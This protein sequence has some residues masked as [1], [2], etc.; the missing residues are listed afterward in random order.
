MAI[1]T[2]D[3]DT[4]IASKQAAGESL[5]IDKIVFAYFDGLDTSATPPKAEGKPSIS[6]IVATEN[7][8]HIGRVNGNTVVY[9]IVM[10][11]DMG[12]WTFNWMGLYSSAE[13]KVIAIAYTPIQQKR[14]TVGD[15]LGNVYNKNFALEF[16]GAADTTGA[17]IDAASWQID[18]TARLQTMDEIQRASIKNVYGQA[19]FIGDAMRV[20]FNGSDYIIKSGRA[21][22]GGLFDELVSDRVI[23]PGA[24]PKTIWLDAYQQKTM[25]GVQS[26]FDVVFNDGSDLP[27]Y[28]AD[29]VGHS[30]IKLATINSQ[31]NI[32]DHRQN[33]MEDFEVF[34]K[35]NSLNPK[36]YGLGLSDDVPRPPDQNV[37]NLRHAGFYSVDD[38]S[39]GTPTG[40]GGT[41]ICF[42]RNELN[43]TL[44]FIEAN[45]QRLY[46][47]NRQSD[48]WQDKWQAIGSENS[49]SAN[50]KAG[51]MALVHT[52]AALLM[53]GDPGDSSDA[54]VEGPLSRITCND[55]GGNM[56]IRR[57]CYF[58]EG[59]DRYSA[60]G[61]GAAKIVLSTDSTDG[62]VQFYTA[63]K[64]VKGEVITWG[65]SFKIELN[66]LLFNGQK[67][68]DRSDLSD[69]V[70]STSTA[71]PASSKAVK[72]AYDLAGSKA[73]SQ[74]THGSEDLP[75][76]TITGKGVV[77]L[78]EIL[79]G[80]SK[81]KALAEVVGKQLQD[82][83][84]SLSSS[85]ADTVSSLQGEIDGKSSTGHG[86]SISDVSGL[87]DELDGK[88]DSGH[89]HAISGISGL[90]EAL[91]AKSNLTLGSRVWQGTSTEIDFTFGQGLY[92]VF[93]SP[94]VGSFYM[95]GLFY[96]GS[97]TFNAPI[98]I[99]SNFSTQVEV[100]YGRIKIVKYNFGG[101]SERLNLGSIYRVG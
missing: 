87:Q 43:T 42:S 36:H 44:L 78:S 28:V 82:S 86:H 58:K 97:N 69:S 57:G 37:L 8:T 68:L 46:F 67:V 20:Q 24:L 16:L 56:C 31:S 65:P 70:S 9:S 88:T 54:S 94:G 73:N 47:R 101:S 84:N 66:Q 27:D 92:Y 33:V 4:L 48:I 64:G 11:S 72:S 95:P 15:V 30:F 61:Y 53:D 62:A 39:D 35:G 14:K 21:C 75:D 90:Q 99:G 51:H 76:A 17:T 89:G 10:P 2:T 13:D 7:I 55:G 5:V 18:Y 32:V 81:S 59:A 60:D 19:G 38:G 77:Q 52:A 3:G 79:T 26:T 6:N 12:T 100:V 96:Y 40:A 49:T 98:Q 41:C 45:T 74:H 85:M 22:L 25:A 23:E 1:V 71:T 34:H 63:I 80:T 91:D 83:I 93:Y 29:G 50:L